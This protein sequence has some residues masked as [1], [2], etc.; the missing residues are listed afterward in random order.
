MIFQG[1]RG[2]TLRVN[3]FYQPEAHAIIEMNRAVTAIPTKAIP[4]MLA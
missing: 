3:G 2:V 1:L 4:Y